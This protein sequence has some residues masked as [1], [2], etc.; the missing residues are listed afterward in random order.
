MCDQCP[1]TCLSEDELESHIYETHTLSSLPQSDDSELLP[2]LSKSAHNKKLSPKTSP[3]GIKK[4]PIAIGKSIGNLKATIMKCLPDGIKAHVQSVQK[5]AMPKVKRNLANDQVQ[6]KTQAIKAVDLTTDL[7]LVSKPRI[8][9]WKIEKIVDMADAVQLITKKRLHVTKQLSTALARKAHPEKHY[10]ALRPKLM[11]GGPLLAKQRRQQKQKQ[12]KKPQKL[13]DTNTTDNKFSD[14]DL[15]GEGLSSKRKRKPKMFGHD[16]INFDQITPD[17]SMYAG[18]SSNSV[19]IS[20]DVDDSDDLSDGDVDSIET[21]MNPTV[22]KRQKKQ[23]LSFDEDELENHSR[24]LEEMLQMEEEIDPQ[25]DEAVTSP[26]HKSLFLNETFAN[27]VKVTGPSRKRKANT[28]LMTKAQQIEE[29]ISDMMVK[30]SDQDTADDDDEDSREALLQKYAAAVQDDKPGKRQRKA[31]S[32]GNDFISTEQARQNTKLAEYQAATK[33][34]IGRPPKGWIKPISDEIKGPKKPKMKY[35]G[36]K[37]NPKRGPP[38]S[39]GV[40][41]QIAHHRRMSDSSTGSSQH[42]KEANL[43]WMGKLSNI[44]DEV[45]KTIAPATRPTQK[46]GGIS[47]MSSGSMAKTPGEQVKYNVINRGGQVLLVPTSA[48]SS[49]VVSSKFGVGHSI[50]KMG[51]SVSNAIKTVKTANTGAPAKTTSIKIVKSPMLQSSKTSNPISVSNLPPGYKILKV[52]GK[53]YLCKTT[54]KSNGDGSTVPTPTR[55]ITVKKPDIDPGNTKI[56]LMSAL[57]AASQKTS[58]VMPS[59]SVMSPK[60]IKVPTGRI[61]EHPKIVVMSASGNKVPKPQPTMIVR[62]KRGLTLFP[63]GDDDDDDNEME[64]NTIAAPII[65]YPIKRGQPQSILATSSLVSQQSALA[66]LK[67]IENGDAMS[68]DMSGASDIL[69]NMV[70]MGDDGTVMDDDVD[71][72]QD[73]NSTSTLDPQMEEMLNLL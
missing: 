73:I 4:V 45:K 48:G 46:S 19:R 52:N 32:Y 9:L 47:V 20:D 15:E 2:S 27:I 43:P 42:D 23:D 24:E 25:G 21:F 31:K 30:Y 60:I 54:A 7:R 36:S 56:T 44:L 61:T 71:Q 37:N 38:K 3:I 67:A 72:L 62:R 22:K 64:D 16:F 41:G 35:T 49:K 13:I 34:R 28:K 14:V 55:K 10:A 70:I 51:S 59:T 26:V 33:R 29:E 6:P 50:L 17:D 11:A 40:F 18:S 69:R 68:G 8:C 66:Q 5:K 57:P 39:S 63:G 65:T 58:L 1:Y 12:N 53:T